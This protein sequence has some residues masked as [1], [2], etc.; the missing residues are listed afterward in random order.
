[1][2]FSD[3]VEDVPV[4]KSHE[5]QNDADV[6]GQR[7]DTYPENADADSSAGI[8]LFIFLYWRYSLNEKVMCRVI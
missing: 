1:M 3:A 5:S 2:I 6:H 7:H 8:L 4:S